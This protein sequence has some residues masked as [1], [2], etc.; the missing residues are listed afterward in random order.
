MLAI[1]VE[2][3]ATLQAATDPPGFFEQISQVSVLNLG[4]G[5]LV[6]L[7]IVGFLRGWI[8]TR[9]HYNDIVAQR[10]RWE[11]AYWKEKEAS[12][13]QDRQ[14]QEL[15]EVARSMKSFMDAF[16]KAVMPE[17]EER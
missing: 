15:L 5:G 4:A 8:F 10:D 6:A 2:P 17:E 13:L 9:A 12:T 3:G 11:N 16:P 14:K 7:F 1:L